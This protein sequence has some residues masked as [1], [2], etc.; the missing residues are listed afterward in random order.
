MPERARFR[1]PLESQRVHGLQSLRKSPRQQFH[2][3]FPLSPEQFSYKTS[4]L[5]R[6]EIL[7]LFGDRLTELSRIL[8]II[9]RNSQDLFKRNYPKNANHFLQLLLQFCNL[10]KI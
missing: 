9:Q 3:N 7:G 8:V 4:V 1:T 10:Q 5:V 2:L 6:C